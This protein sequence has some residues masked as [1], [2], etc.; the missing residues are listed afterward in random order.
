MRDLIGLVR[1]IDA[2]QQHFGGRHAHF[3]AVDVH[4]RQLRLDN[5]RLRRVV[6]AADDDILRYRQ[7]QVLQGGHEADGDKIVGADESGGKLGHFL[8]LVI[9]PAGA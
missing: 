4:G 2:G 7:I 6:E 3:I 9:G 1:M 5:S 8:E